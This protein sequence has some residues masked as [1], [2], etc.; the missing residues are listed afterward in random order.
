[1]MEPGLEL[2]AISQPADVEIGLEQGLLADI[3]C[4]LLVA[5][6][7]ESESVDRLLPAHR[8]PVEG[9]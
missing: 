2:P 6:H 7:T 1:M 9:Y 3:P 8:Q 5:K 4:I